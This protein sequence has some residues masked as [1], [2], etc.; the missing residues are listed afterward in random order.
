MTIFNIYGIGTLIQCD[1]QLLYM[2]RGHELEV[3]TYAVQAN[4]ICRYPRD[5]AANRDGRQRGIIYIYF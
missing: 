4:V 1:T 3:A 5:R 2:L